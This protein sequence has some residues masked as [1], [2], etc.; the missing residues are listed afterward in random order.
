LSREVVADERRAHSDWMKALII[1]YHRV[2]TREQG[3]FGLGMEAQRAAVAAYASATGGDILA[4]YNEVET[5]RKDSLRNRP[6]LVKAL[7]HARRCKATLVI[8]RLDRLARSVLVTSQLMAS[9]VNF[10][11]CD[12]P[13]ANR[14]TIHILA[15]LAEHES[16]MISERVK[17]AFTAKR[18]RGDDF[19][20]PGALFPV[21]AAIMGT[22]GK[23]RG[24]SPLE[25]D[26]C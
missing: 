21:G 24:Y 25:T 7:A 8:A 22:R 17:A 2:S 11:A 13:H 16:R 23:H 19:K 5:A 18:A 12:N 15:A 1:A 26:L 4:S 20:R 10:V 6:E 3:N 14:F 9:G